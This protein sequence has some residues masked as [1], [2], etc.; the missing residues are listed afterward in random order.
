MCTRVLWNSN[1]FAVLAGRSM[2]WPESTE[3]LIVVFPRGRQR[4]GGLLVTEVVVPDN[5]LRWTSTYG[6]VVTTVYGLGTVDGVNE[7]GLGVH[8]LYLKSTDVGTRNPDLPGLHTGLWAQYLLDGAATVGEALA[9]M[10]GVQL[11]MVGANGHDATLHLAIEDAAGDSAIIELAGGELVVHHG[12]EFTLMTNDPTYDEQ[13]RL[14]AA[15]DFSHPS[16]DMPLPGNVN[17][18]DRFQRAAYYSALL[19]TPVAERPAVASVM[20]IMRN[21]SVPFGA[22]YGE[23]GVYNTEYRTVTDLTHLT[24]FFELTTSPST[25][26]TRLSKLDFTEGA[27]VLAIDPYDESLVGDVTPSFAPRHIGF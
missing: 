15:Q 17:P 13:L 9:L 6:S 18:V 4:D 20:A 27:P 19:P 2:D 23:F 14:L 11:V 26:W 22:P 3:P 5:P 12:R 7:K 25:L 24:Y 8:A 1:D 16:R 10:D 21:V